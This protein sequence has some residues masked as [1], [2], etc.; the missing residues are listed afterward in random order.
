MIILIAAVSMIAAF[1]I[2]SSIPL[3]KVDKNGVKVKQMVELSAD[4]TEPDTR[5]FNKDAI[6]PTVKTVL[7]E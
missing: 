6:N 5:V 7:G 1:A 3:L 2:A 4:V